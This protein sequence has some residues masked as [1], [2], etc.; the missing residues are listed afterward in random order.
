MAY[1]DWGNTPIV[2]TGTGLASNP[3]TA[4]LVAQVDSTQL[5]AI[6]PGGQNF[7]VT[8]IVGASTLATW[9]LEQCLSTGLGSTAVRDDTPV[10]TPT[11]Q[12]GQYVVT[13]KLE[14]GDRLRARLDAAITGTATAKISA[15]PL[16]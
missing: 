6:T 2:S 8:W 12:S 1:F 13:L 14:P 11:N 10:L 16:T 7:R 9:H 15:E 3:D 4:T 5:G